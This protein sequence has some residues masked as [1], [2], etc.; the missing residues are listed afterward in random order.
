MAPNVALTLGACCTFLGW[1]NVRGGGLH[2]RHCALFEN[3]RKVLVLWKLRD[4]ERVPAS[5]TASGGLKCVK[6]VRLP[7]VY[8]VHVHV[9]VAEARLREIA[10]LKTGARRAMVQ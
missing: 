8:R 4:C 6:C 5:E 7:H 3:H 9:H 10:L 2:E 1:R